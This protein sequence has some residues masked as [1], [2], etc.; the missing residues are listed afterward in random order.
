MSTDLLDDRPQIAGI[1]PSDLAV[2]SKYFPRDRIDFETRLFKNIGQPIDHGL[3][4]TKH[5]QLTGC[6]SVRPLQDSNDVFEWPWIGISYGHKA[7]AFEDE[8][9]RR[10]TWSIGVEICQERLGH[11][12]GTV[13]SVEAGE[14]IRFPPFLHGSGPRCRELIP[15][16]DL[17]AG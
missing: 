10:P 5:D 15:R 6:I 17:L 9:D 3:N 8:S 14:R 11:E 4:K 16:G 12:L 13:F 1:R 7:A 2:A